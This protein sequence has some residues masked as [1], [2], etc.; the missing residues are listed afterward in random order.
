MVRNLLLL[1]ILLV[2]VAAGFFAGSWSGR[3]AKAALAKVEATGQALEAE[4]K[5]QVA[6]LN[7]RMSTLVSDYTRD[8]QAQDDAHANQIKAMDDILAGAKG[9]VATLE[10]TRNDSLSRIAQLKTELGGATTPQARKDIE[11]AIAVQEGSVK[12][13]SVAILSQQCLETPVPAD[14]LANWNGKQP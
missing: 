3:S 13:Q 7:A 4:H 9:R 10:K 6:E 2:G 14:V 12:T 1:V 11:A 8:K 5:K